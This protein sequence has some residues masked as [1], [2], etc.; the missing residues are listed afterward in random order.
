M[1]GENLG[2]E[3]RCMI[4][5]MENSIRYRINPDNI[6]DSFSGSVHMLRLIGDVRYRRLYGEEEYQA[7][8][9][10]KAVLE[11]F[12]AEMQTAGRLG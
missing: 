3:P 12:I 7:T 5:G 6:C 1:G 11:G 10:I 2:V 8:L 9:N 4:M